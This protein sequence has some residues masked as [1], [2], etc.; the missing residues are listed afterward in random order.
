MAAAAL[1]QRAAR[2]AGYIAATVMLAVLAGISFTGRW[3]TDASLERVGSSG[4][5]ALP[6]ARVAQVEIVAGEKSLRF[7]RADGGWEVDGA[8]VVPAL[9]KHIDTAIGFL[10]VSEPRRKFGPRDYDPDK[11]AEFGLDPPTMVVSVTSRGGRTISIAFGEPT[12]AENSQFVHLLG[13]PTIDLL[14]RYVGVEWQMALDMAE[15][16]APT[17][18]DGKPRPNL[19]FLPMSFANIWAVEIVQNG[20][21]TRFER[22]PAGDWFHHVGVHVHRPGGFVHRA[23]P[24]TAPLIAAEF[25]AMEQ[26]S[27]ESV[28]AKHPDDTLLA[29]DGVEHPSTIMLMYA[30]DSFGPVVRVEFGNPTPDGF[31]RYARVRE[32]DSLVSVPRYVAAHVDKLLQIAQSSAG[33]LVGA[34]P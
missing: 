20:A 14:S 18:A 10:N 19:L 23:D 4:I 29:E 15:R 17:A 21:L 3:P 6:A 22:D 1:N 2:L 24:K 33:Q 34:K 26:A 31:G 5:V 7:D 32:T 8:A 30:R 11:I 27:V 9:A 28:V 13:Q 16:L 25:A 12:P